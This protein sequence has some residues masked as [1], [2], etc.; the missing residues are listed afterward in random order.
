MIETVVRF[1]RCQR[2]D[3]VSWVVIVPLV[4]FIFFFGAV[5]LHLDRVRAG[6]AMAAR[7]GARAYGIALEN[8]YLPAR[9]IAEEKVRDTLQAEGL[10][11]PGS[12]FL[13]D[14]ATPARGER[15]VAVEFSDTGEWATCTIT[16]YLPNPFTRL[17][18]LIKSDNAFPDHFVFTVKGAAKHEVENTTIE[19]D[20]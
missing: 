1:L 6:V 5:F 12:D 3:V 8:P 15:G 13:A 18:R 17:F 19:G 11:P 10:M 4:F 7:D 2:G 16:Y 20:G 14:G 9:D